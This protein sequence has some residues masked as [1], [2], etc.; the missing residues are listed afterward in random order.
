MKRL[1]EALRLAAGEG[2]DEELLVVGVGLRGRGGGGGVP[3]GAQAPARGARLASAPRRCPAPVLC[4][5]VDLPKKVII[6]EFGL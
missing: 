3:V 4:I 2:G 5:V 1:D 6:M